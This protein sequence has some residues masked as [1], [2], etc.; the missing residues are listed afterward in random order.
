MSRISVFPTDSDD[1]SVFIASQGVQAMRAVAAVLGG[2]ACIYL[3]LANHFRTDPGIVPWLALAL[4][5]LVLVFLYS[6]RFRAAMVALLWGGML[7]A[8][9]GGARRSG[10][11]APILVVLP[12]MVTAGGWLV[13]RRQAVSMMVVACLGVLLIAW[14]QWA[15][16]PVTGAAVAPFGFPLV[17][18]AVIVCGGILG[19]MSGNSFKHQFRKAVALSNNL[20]QQLTEVQDARERLH[21]LVYVDAITG[22]RSAH[23]QRQ[24]MQELIDQHTP[25]S[26]L[27][28]NLDGFRLVND[29]FGPTV[30]NSVIAAV[31]EILARV[32]AHHGE[33]ARSTGAEFTVLTVNL[34][35][36]DP[37]RQ[38]ASSILER[39]RAPL[40]VGELT[41]YP[42]ASIGVARSPLNTVQI[43]E[44]FRMA[45][46]A[47]HATKAHGGKNVG[48]YEPHM[49]ADAQVRLWFDHH[50][51]LAL[52]G[53]QLALHFQ[54]K[55]GLGDGAVQSVEAL[56]RWTHPERGAIR[57][58]QFIARAEVSGW[59]IPIGR[60]VLATAA[61]QAAEWAAAGLSIRIAVNVSAKQLADTELLDRLQAAQT[62]AGGL[63]DIE[64][65]ESCVAENEHESTV[66]MSRCRAMGF[67]VHL[68]DFGTGF[69][70]LARL[71]QLP[72]TLI[73]LDRA[74][75]R[76]IG[77][78]ARSESLLRAMV[79]IGR[80]LDLAMVAEGVETETQA[81]FLGDLGVQYAQGWLYAAAMAPQACRDWVHTQH[82]TVA[83]R[84]AGETIKLLLKQ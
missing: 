11:D 61:Q 71:A 79:S 56:L 27:T 21:R 62:Q 10:F 31:G 69:S 30:G 37:L 18:L 58:D 76:P 4:T 48:S 73:K 8:L 75:V 35:D 12:V 55:V 59:I 23:G 84:R 6:N 63:L 19:S 1:Q 17:L 44:L 3:V 80:E 51:R 60:W 24:R 57:P 65:T 40:K 15:Q 49:D 82:R 28:V 25:F 9:F 53:R 50:L 52:E 70:S 13:D 5:V 33:T 66:F 42:D 67:G 43:D 7:L 64:L 38:L 2:A 81:Q 74:F 22:L 78:D 54:P 29:N 83:A 77:T 14:M 45:D 34:I 47:L 39:L 26:L 68:D 41:I 16:I 20:S 72:L 36:L 32:V 46:V